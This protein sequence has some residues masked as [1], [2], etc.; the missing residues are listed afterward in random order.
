MQEY[1]KHEGRLFFNF[2]I[3]KVNMREM[4]SRREAAATVP[5]GD[6]K[7]SGRTGAAACRTC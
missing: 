6:V 7:R 1:T 5:A 4:K 2:I 3:R